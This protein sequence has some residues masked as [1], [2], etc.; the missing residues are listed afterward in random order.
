M[1][2]L[3]YF[4]NF[5]EECV[6]AWADEG[7]PVAYMPLCGITRCAPDYRIARR[8]SPE[9]VV[10]YIV[11]GSGTF[12]T[13]AREF[14]PRA[15]DVYIAHTGSDHEYYPDPDDP[16]EKIWFNLRGSLVGELVRI[17]RLDR[18]A[19]L[20]QCGLETLF[21]ESLATMRANLGNAHESATLVMHRLFYHLAGAARAPGG[22]GSAEAEKLKRFLDASVNG[23]LNM[24]RAARELGRSES[25]CRR[26]FRAAYGVSPYGYFLDRK[27]ELA[28]VLVERGDRRVKEIA[29]EL[30][31]ADPFYFSRAYKRRHGVAPSA[32]LSPKK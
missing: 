7:D 25:Q 31:F 20:P 27:L 6:V 14:Q 24:A 8:D 17:Y 28:R 4:A 2:I 5:N 21:R 22:S 15:G 13:G 9:C 29:A 10:E 19:Y 23:T 12:R 32:P 16:W 26:I 11:R 1:S 30:G 3:R 18:V